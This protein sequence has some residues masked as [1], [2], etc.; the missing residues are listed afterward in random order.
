[1][2]TQGTLDRREFVKNSLDLH[3]G[4]GRSLDGGQKDPAQR[5]P[6]GCAEASLE[7]L[8]KKVA[9]GRT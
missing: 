5:I 1:M 9:V 6:D 4:Y 3:G 7:G 8:G 2:T